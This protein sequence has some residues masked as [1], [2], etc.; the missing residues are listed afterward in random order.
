MKNNI[1]L[2]LLNGKNSTKLIVLQK[3][4]TTISKCIGCAVLLIY[5]PFK[6]FAMH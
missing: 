2:I 6:V 1:L 4:M 5:W 3:Q